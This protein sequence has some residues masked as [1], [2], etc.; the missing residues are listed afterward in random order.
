MTFY[1]MIRRIEDKKMNVIY[2]QL[3]ERYLNVLTLLNEKA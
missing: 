1:E 3:N 2:D